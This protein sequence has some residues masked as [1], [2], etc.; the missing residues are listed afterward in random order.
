MF[1]KTEWQREYRKNN[2]KRVSLELQKDQFEILK[3]HVAITGET[4]N[5]FIKRAIRE[6]IERDTS[7]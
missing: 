7:K 4:V 5:G 1:N 2:L 6:T 3:N